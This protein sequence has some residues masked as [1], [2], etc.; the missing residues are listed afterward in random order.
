MNKNKEY[1]IAEHVRLLISFCMLSFCCFFNVQNAIAQTFTKLAD[2]NGSANG[3]FPQGG[4]ISDGSF[5]YGMTYDG[6]ANAEG[7]IFKILPDG[8]NYS[9]LFDFNYVST[10][11]HPNGSLLKIGTDLYG[12]TSAGGVS[13][14]G[15]I[16]RIGVTG[17]GYTMLHE[18]SGSNGNGPLGSLT[19]VGGFLYGTTNLGGANNAG[20]VFRIQPNGT[21]FSLIHEFGG[22]LAGGVTDGGLPYSDVISDGTYLYGTTGQGGT[23]GDG[24]IYRMLPD[25][26]NYSILHH[27]T[28][29]ENPRGGL[30]S[31][32]TH[33]YGMAFGGGTPGVNVGYIYKLMG[34]G[35]GFQSLLDFDFTTG[36]SPDGELFLADE[37]LYGLARNYGSNNAGVLFNIQTDGTGFQKLHEFDGAATGSEPVG[38]L[39][40]DGVTLYGMT[41]L[42][43]ANNLGTIFSMKPSCI[44][45]SELNALQ[46]LYESTDGAN[47]GNNSNWFTPDVNTWVG[48][49]LTGCAVTKIELADNGLTGILPHE[50][51]NLNALEVLDLNENNLRGDILFELSGLSNLAI[52]N[53]SNNHFTYMADLTSGLLDEATLQLNVAS[54]ALDFGDLEPNMSFP[55]FNYVPQ[56]NLPPGDVVP[57][58]EGENL[59][60]I[61]DTDGTANA[62]QWFKGGVALTGPG[63][64]D[65]TYIKPGATTADLGE[66]YVEVTNSIVPGLILQSKRYFVIPSSCPVSLSTTGELDLTFQTDIV[67]GYSTAAVETQSANKVL[68]SMSGATVNGQAV[69]G[70]VRLNNDGSLDNTF[71]AIDYYPEP[72]QLVVMTDEAF[73][74]M[75]VTVHPGTQT[76]IHRLNADGTP[77]NAFN[78]ASPLYYASTI[79]A[80]TEGLAGQIVFS[81]EGTENGVFRLNADGT[82]DNSFQ[83]D[84]VATK[85][86]V[87]TDN[88]VVFINSGR[89]YRLLPDGSADA[90]FDL[91]SGANQE[92]TDFAIQADGK[93]VVI[94]Y[95]GE[96]QGQVRFGIARLNPDGSLDDSFAPGGITNLLPGLWEAVVPQKVLVMNDGKILIGGLFEYV[97]AA[98]RPNLVR[99]NTNGTV[100]CI[101][102]QQSTLTML[103]DFS[104]QSDRKII[105][106]DAGAF[107][108]PIFIE[109][110]NNAI[111]VIQ[112]TQQPADATVCEGTTAQFTTSASG[113][114]GI[115]YRW[116]YSP[117]GSP[118]SFVDVSDGTNYSGATTATLTVNTVGN[119]G[120]GR[121]RCRINGTFAEEVFTHDEGLFVTIPPTAPSTTGAVT[122][123]PGTLILNA[124]GGTNGQY[125]WYAVATGGVALSGQT[126]STYTTPSLTATTTYHVAVNDGTCESVRTAVTATINPTPPALTTAGATACSGNTVT[127][128]ASGGTNGQYRWYTVATGGTAI[129]GETNSSYATPSLTV[130]TT[131][132]VSI[133]NGTCESLRTAV[134]A[135]ITALPNPPT[136]TAATVCNPSTALLTASGGT[137]GQYRW[138]TVATG[139]TAISGQTNSTY[140]TPILTATTTFYVS[141]HNGTCESLR[142][143]AMATVSGPCNQPP[144]IRTTAIT[145]Q[146]EGSTKISLTPLLSDPDNNLDP[147]SLRVAVQPASG[148]LAT[149][150]ATQHLNLD[151]TGINF[152][153]MD[154]LTI[155]VCDF[156]NACGHNQLSI[157]VVGDIIVYNAISPNGDDKNPTLLLRYIEVLDETRRNKVSIFNR[158]GDVVWDGEDYNNTTVV[159]SGQ[160]KNGGDLPSGTYFYKIEFA[161]GR[162]IE[163]GF[164]SLR[165]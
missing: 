139:G 111:A 89:L 155:E 135:T 4:L 117:N 99:L 142:A 78:S 137:N 120:E 5:L 158:W 16:F 112:I 152:S 146:V 165:K 57:L 52:L 156:S 82:L 164:L 131:Y 122:C 18:F 9:K 51:G 108:T 90:T 12:T 130:T 19:L 94:G 77:D 104:I 13:N 68:M 107:G 88:K 121:Y 65:P 75:I 34:N 15:T 86:R 154:Q 119:F 1:K 25:G 101:F 97:N 84:W 118:L 45:P 50:I 160:N 114:T 11:S 8:T 124:S 41:N 133:H 2:F 87:Q 129:S 22:T 17:T 136:T 126:N 53:L 46:A 49:T 127:L 40:S 147:A 157:E 63:S 85:L 55:N 70:I 3:S 54:N 56:V 134:T 110:L 162:K 36:G 79:T 143:P 43:G 7:T 73:L 93:I 33:L 145:V 159:F 39:I 38:G 60:L 23:S 32:G 71:T 83:S 20:T 153:G 132:Y 61:F 37:T 148:A 66:Y 14:L 21:G 96:F 26:S 27:F 151:Y 72:E 123:G 128:N 31:D 28:N 10:G 74:D 161:S 42:G 62:Y 113:T 81:V 35:T 76:A 116:Q 92:I 67:G 103:Q 141:I 140:T 105:V 115:T 106:S 102:L 109:R 125:R 150:D 95:F 144:V 29:E 163:T 6:G 91:G 80:V 48:V 100:D 59:M 30:T 44:A 24:T 58:I 69:E 47:W 64:T 149:I 98:P 138:Y